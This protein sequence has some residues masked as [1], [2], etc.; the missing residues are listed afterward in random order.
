MSEVLWIEIARGDVHLAIYRFGGS[1]EGVLLLHGLAG[2]G[3]EWS[4][5][6][7]VLT[8]A[9]EVFALD[10]RG[11]ARSE[12]RPPEVSPQAFCSDVVAVIEAMGH[13]RVH[14]VGQSF[15]GHIAFLTA[16]SYPE[17]LSSLVVI[18]ADPDEPRAEVG[19]TAASWVR[20]WHRP[21][22]DRDAALAFFASTSRDPSTWVEGL[23]GR[24]DGYWPRFDL[25]VVL[26]AL[27]AVAVR[28][29]WDE[30]KKVECPTWV[31]RGDRGSL[32]ME[33]AEQMAASL[34]QATVVTIADAGHDVHL[35]QSERLAEVLTAVLHA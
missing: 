12:R 18:E 30:W 29:W 17:L 26:R 19:A 15:G 34:S 10:L 28:S 23:K 22:S 27:G 4:K 33:L 5:L 31:V 8:S 11:H 20:S 7:N 3:G 9:Y 35:E 24:D 2:Y 32:S 21:F 1:G 16:A 14:L 13:E 25:D 6:A